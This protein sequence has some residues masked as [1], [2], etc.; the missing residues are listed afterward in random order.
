MIKKKMD[1]M[2]CPNS[3]VVQKFKYPNALDI[4]NIA[5][6]TALDWAIKIALG[7]PREN[8]HVDPNLLIHCACIYLER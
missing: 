1:K 5:F 2:N 7:F 8:E 4:F 3:E 6:V